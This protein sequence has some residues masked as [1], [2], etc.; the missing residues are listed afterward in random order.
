MS[1]LNNVKCKELSYEGLGVAN[2]D[3]KKLFVY[4]F[5]PNE[6]ANINIIKQTKHISFGIAKEILT[7]STDRINNDFSYSFPLEILDYQKQLEA[8]NNYLNSLFSR[9]LNLKNKILKPII[10]CDNKNNYRNKV[11]IAF[12]T[13]IVDN[14]PRLILVEHQGKSE[15]LVELNS[16]NQTNFIKPQVLET[17]F[18]LLQTYV[19]PSSYKMLKGLTIRINQLNQ[20]DLL[21]LVNNDFDLPKQLVSNIINTFGSNKIKLQEAKLNHKTNTQKIKIINNIDFKMQLCNQNFAI[22]INS[23]FQV[24]NFIANKMFEYI[25]N[26]T[27][28]QNSNTILDLYCGSGIIGQLIGSNNKIIGIDIDKDSII[29]AKNNALI[30]NKINSKYYAGDVYKVISKLNLD[31]TNALVIVDPPRK[32]LSKEFI[33]WF[34]SNKFTQLIYI[35]CD[36][37]TLTRDLIELQKLNYQIDSIQ[38][39]DMFPNTFHLE[40]V[41]LISKNKII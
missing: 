3:D 18:N 30:N 6:V 23:F 10:A 15:K 8:K 32:G 4:N 1:K 21:I 28:D 16:I 41:V 38:P 27:K 12:D 17:I 26:L 40:N 13:K 39:F 29:Q 7:A 9:N 5:L 25:Q 35:S 24:N 11:R 19:K 36:P 37:R 22:D 33:E 20:I 14:N 2:L 31:L 34:N